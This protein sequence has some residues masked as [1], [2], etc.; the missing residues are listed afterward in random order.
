MD[1]IN[2]AR[3]LADTLKDKAQE[4]ANNTAKGIEEVVDE[5]KNTTIE[6]TTSSINAVTDLPATA[7][8]G[9]QAVQNVGKALVKYASALGSALRPL[10]GLKT[11][12]LSFKLH[13]E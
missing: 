5:I 3:N 12:T 11:V 10:N 8:Q 1:F 7:Q 13:A 4:V 6:I 9:F 2:Q